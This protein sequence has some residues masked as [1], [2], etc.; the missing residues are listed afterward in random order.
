MLRQR[1]LLDVNYYPHWAYQGR[2]TYIGRS[3]GSTTLQRTEH[4]DVSVQLS[5]GDNT[6][7]IDE[8]IDG[9]NRQTILAETVSRRQPFRPD[10]PGWIVEGVSSADVLLWAFPRKRPQPGLKVY[11]FN[12][13]RLREW[14]WRNRNDNP[15]LFEPHEIPNRENGKTWLTIGYSIPIKEIP[16]FFFYHS[17]VLIPYQLGLFGGPEMSFAE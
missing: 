15:D 10:V 9:K 4:V 5:D 3:T 1:S 11:T 14:F 8:K 7:L 2:W 16:R 12:F 17:P 13:A 6:L